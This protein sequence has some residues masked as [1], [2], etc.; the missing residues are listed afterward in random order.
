MSA[1]KLAEDQTTE[2][3][4]HLSG[5]E[6]YYFLLLL[7]RSIAPQLHLSGIEIGVTGTATAT[8]QAPQLHLSGIEIRKGE[9]VLF[10]VFPGL[11]CLSPLKEWRVFETEIRNFNLGKYEQI[12]QEM[13]QAGKD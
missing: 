8:E 11:N 6:I 3:Q 7:T 5:I 12:V 10:H 9:P 2:P 13:E 1:K 4:L